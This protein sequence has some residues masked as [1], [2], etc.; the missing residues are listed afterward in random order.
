MMNQQQP[1]MGGL[2][3]AGAGGGQFQPRPRSNGQIG[4]IPEAGYQPPPGV[5]SRLGTKDADPAQQRA[6]TRFVTTGMGLLYQQAFWARAV[7]MLKSSDE[8][9]RGIAEVASILIVQ[10]VRMYEKGGEKV[11]HE[12]LLHGGSEIMALVAEAAMASG[13]PKL[14]PDQA[15]AALLLTADLVQLQMSRNGMLEHEKINSAMVQFRNMDAEG[16]FDDWKQPEPQPAEQPMP[17]EM[18]Q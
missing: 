6:Y 8:P 1:P 3:G 9:A 13:L 16:M 12:V 10:A 2:G 14:N 11:P 18:P 7:A 4:R 15:E 5:G 17:Q